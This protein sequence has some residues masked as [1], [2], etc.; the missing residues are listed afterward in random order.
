MARKT[1]SLYRGMRIFSC[2]VWDLVPQPGI[3]PR[4]PA[5]GAQ[6][7]SHSLVLIFFSLSFSCFIFLPFILA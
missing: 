6:N 2:S 3:E 5:L 7:L 4:P 1:F